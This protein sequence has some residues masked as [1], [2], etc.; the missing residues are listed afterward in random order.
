MLSLLVAFGAGTTPEK[1][2]ALQAVGAWEARPLRTMWEQYSE[3][4]R[5]DHW[6]EYAEHYERHFPRPDGRT[7]L[8]LLEIGV[9]SGGS[10]RA[11]R[12]YY[13]APLTYVG[14]DI[15]PECMRTHSPAENIFIEIGSQLNG[16]FLQ[17][18]AP[19]AMAFQ[20]RKVAC[21]ASVCTWARSRD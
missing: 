10:A 7:P 3:P 11:W 20:V 17:V 18:R 4:P 6:L 12:Q 2:A 1:T 19:V 15:N 8:K 14:I 13:G 16:T 21:P 9:Q 5:L